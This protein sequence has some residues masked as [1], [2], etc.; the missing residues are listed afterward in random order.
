MTVDRK[1]K[2]EIL[3]VTPEVR[4][5]KTAMPRKAIREG[6]YQIKADDIADKILKQVLFELVLAREISV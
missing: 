2:F 4:K 1:R 6:T 3:Y 5:E